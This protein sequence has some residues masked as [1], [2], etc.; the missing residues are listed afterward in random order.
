[1]SRILVVIL[2]VA[3]VLLMVTAVP[4]EVLTSN[5]Q[6]RLGVGGEAGFESVQGK[7]FLVISP[8]IIYGLSPNLYLV[9]GLTIAD[10]LG[11]SVF[12][13]NVDPCY[14]FTPQNQT[15]MYAG[16]T[17]GISS[18]DGSSSLYL[19]PIGGIQYFL[20]RNLAIDGQLRLVFY[21]GAGGGTSFGARVKVNCY[22]R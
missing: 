11:T 5:M 22:L 6:G 10:Y 19:G 1:M 20:T 15:G 8:E 2:T 13:I 21:T 3:M 7:S 18:V 9:G 14:N 16:G 12:S 17:I 4:A